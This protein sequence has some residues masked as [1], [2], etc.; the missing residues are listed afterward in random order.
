MLPWKGLPLVLVVQQKLL[1]PWHPVGLL[2]LMCTNA[3]LMVTTGISAGASLSHQNMVYCK[4]FVRGNWDWPRE[5]VLKDQ[6]ST[7]DQW[8]LLNKYPCSWPPSL[9][10]KS[11][12]CRLFWKFPV[13]LNAVTQTAIWSWTFSIFPSFPSL[14]HFL[15]SITSASKNYNLSKLVF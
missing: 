5:S 13:G 11:V 7:R 3:V 6:L 12:F 8:E 2:T 15:M 10:V 14:T 1:V 9:K 4:V